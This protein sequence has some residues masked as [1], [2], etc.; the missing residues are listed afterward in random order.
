MIDQ[1]EYTGPSNDCISYDIPKNVPYEVF[2]PVAHENVTMS[3]YPELQDM[4]YEDPPKNYILHILGC[5][6]A[7]FCC[8]TLFPL[9]MVC[10]IC[11]FKYMNLDDANNFY[12][13]L[14]IRLSIMITTLL[15]L[16]AFLASICYG[17]YYIST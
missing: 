5:C 1:S 11:T 7:Y 14:F 13:K 16:F 12:F 6:F 17:I 9:N 4:Y 10:G 15:T 3:Y 2:Y 8:A